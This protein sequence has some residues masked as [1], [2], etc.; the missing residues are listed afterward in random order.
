MMINHFIDLFSYEYNTFSLSVWLLEPESFT[1][2][3]S[4]NSFLS[5]R[6]KINKQAKLYLLSEWNVTALS[7]GPSSSSLDCSTS[8]V[9]WFRSY[10]VLSSTSDSFYFTACQ[11]SGIFFSS[12]LWFKLWWRFSVTLYRWSFAATDWV[13]SAKKQPFLYH[14]F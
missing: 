14:F 7:V 9:S 1:D 13:V 11:V 6:E 10:S 3:S 4:N 8:V 2:L 5:K 12:M